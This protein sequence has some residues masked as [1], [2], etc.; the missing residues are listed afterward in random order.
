MPTRAVLGRPAAVGRATRRRDGGTS[1]Y[2]IRRALKLNVMASNVSAATLISLLRILRLA[3][4]RERRE[5]DVPCVDLLLE[6]VWNVGDDRDHGDE[7]KKQEQTH[8][9]DDGFR[10]RVGPPA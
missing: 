8:R 10:F 5:R 6:G 4:R 7:P 9:V 2:R 1:L 3:K